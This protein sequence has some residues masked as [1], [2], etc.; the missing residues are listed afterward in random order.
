MNLLAAAI[1]LAQTS[2]L[3]AQEFIYEKAS[4]PSCHA[5]TLIPVRDGILAAWFGGKDEGEPDVS[6][7]TSRRTQGRWTDP[8]MAADGVQRD[9]KRYPCWNPVLFRPKGGG[10]LLFY[11]VGPNPRQ[12][13]GEVKQSRDDGRTWGPAKRLPEGI[14]GPIK[15]KPVQHKDRIISP[16]S[17]EHDGWRLHM[18]LSTDGGNSFT[19][20]RPLN[21][22][23]RIGAIQPTILHM[24]GDRLAALC[25]TRQQ[26]IGITTSVDGGRTWSDVSLLDVP[27]PNSGIDA[28][29]LK[30]GRH[31]LVYNPVAKGRTPLSVAVSRDGKSWTKVLDLE[32][33]PGEY[34]YPAVVQGPDGMV[35][36]LYTWK[37][38]RMRYAVI[39]PAKL[40]TP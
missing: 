15:N 12:W 33:Q 24:G 32:T 13:W 29:T 17:T 11:K 37:R 18:E 26:R 34:S 40:P 39:N 30:D 1:L 22:G 23:R 35:H 28:V 6:I 8:V 5:G 16:S 31:L 9:G 14:L 2:G 20:T 38:E 19:A 21:D 25:R 3:S 10:L 4:F 27:N 36:I 7:W